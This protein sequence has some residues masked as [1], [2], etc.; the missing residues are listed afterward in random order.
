MTQEAMMTAEAVTLLYCKRNLFMVLTIVF[1]GSVREFS[2][3]VLVPLRRDF[4]CQV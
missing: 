3:V 2:G 1:C 4:L